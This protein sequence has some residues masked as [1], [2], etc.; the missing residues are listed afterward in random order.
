M[1]KITQNLKWLVTL[2]TMIVSMGAWA[3]D[4]ALSSAENITQDGI[5]VSFDKASGS[6]A[7]AWYDAG[8]RLYANNTI[9]ISSANNI[10]GITFNWEKQGSKA[11]ASVSASVGTYTHPSA[12]GEGTWTGSSKSITFTLGNSGQLQLNTFTV[13]CETGGETPVETVATPTF[14]VAEGTYKKAQSVE[15]SCATDGASVYYTT[16]GTEPSTAS[17][18]YSDPLTISSTTTIKAIAVKDGYK[19]SEIATAIYTIM[20]PILGYTIDFEHPLSDY[21]LWTFTNISKQSDIT[22]HG[23]TFYG[24]NVNENGNGVTSA[25]IQTKEPV[26][27][28]ATFTC[29]VSKTSSNTKASTWYVE[30]SSDEETWT[31]VASHSASTMGK[32]EWIEVTA[33]LSGYSNV[34]VRLKYDGSTAI[35][36]VDDIS[37]TLGETVDVTV[38]EGGKMESNGKYY[39][40]Y[41]NAE[42]ALDFSAV[43]G[44]NAYIVVT[45]PSDG[46]IAI[47][48]VD[49]V[50]AGTAVL[51]EG[52]EATTYQVPV[53]S[54]AV[55][56][57]TNYLQIADSNTVGDGKNIYIL[58]AGTSGVGFYPVKENSKIPEGKVYLKIPGTDGLI[59]AFLSLGGNANAINGIEAEVGAGIIYNLNG[60]RV[61]A[62]VKG[63]LYIVNG[64]KM[65]VK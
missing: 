21:E 63:G 60:Q 14:S 22:A 25:T 15:I 51:I 36:A 41:S 4:F 30:V 3:T 64:K 9:T 49:V 40:T 27:N 35:R 57:S 20:P 65:L 46:S 29:Y 62:P 11:F 59:K 2:L 54:S 7:P 31:Q 23:G 28:P 16:D 48:S 33:D 26:V 58:S 45:P 55:A 38:T 42:K 12:A 1:K 32:G 6:S 53:V 44:I 34:F 47:Q 52:E 10:T 43:D 39:A 19:N 50:P 17:S 5:T 24:A 37:V 56:I 8:L 18:L 61:A 13:T